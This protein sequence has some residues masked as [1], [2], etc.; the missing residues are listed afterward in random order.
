M[1]A[2]FTVTM[3]GT[4]ASLLRCLGKASAGPPGWSARSGAQVR[5]GDRQR[6]RSSTLH[7]AQ[8]IAV[9]DDLEEVAASQELERLARRRHL[10]DGHPAHEITGQVGDIDVAALEAG[11][12]AEARDNVV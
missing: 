11:P 3:A 4:S 8:D 7:E 9:L 6:G 2:Y 5:V 10:A 1:F 12:N